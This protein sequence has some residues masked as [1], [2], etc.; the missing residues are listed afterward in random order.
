[1][2]PIFSYPVD[3]AVPALRDPLS[4]DQICRGQA[5]H[6]KHRLLPNTQQPQNL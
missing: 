5:L 1:M 6:L 4:Q 3:I 2:M